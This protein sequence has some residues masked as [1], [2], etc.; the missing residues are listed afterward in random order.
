LKRKN[1]EHIACTDSLDICN[2]NPSYS[3]NPEISRS[4]IMPKYGICDRCKEPSILGEVACTNSKPWMC[5]QC[6]CEYF[7]FPIEK[8]KEVKQTLLEQYAKEKALEKA[9]R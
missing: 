1:N 7:G 3:S 6:A 2:H 5:P 4:D 9:K 8:A